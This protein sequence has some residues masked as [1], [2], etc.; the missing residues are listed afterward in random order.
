MTWQ[1]AFERDKHKVGRAVH[2]AWASEKQR[3]GFAD[4]PF[5][6]CPR[7]GNAHIRVCN[8]KVGLY[9]CHLGDDECGWGQD[10]HHSDMLDYDQLSPNI[11]EYDIATGIVGFRLGYEACQADSSSAAGGERRAPA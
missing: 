6:R 2:E 8:H 4:H 10:V 5:V 7:Q 1:E 3:Q 11:Q 9:N